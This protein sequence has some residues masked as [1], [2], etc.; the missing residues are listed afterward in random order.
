MYIVNYPSVPSIIHTNVQVEDKWAEYKQK[1]K[2]HQK[3]LEYRI[4]ALEADRLLN[5]SQQCV[6]Q[7]SQSLADGDYDSELWALLQVS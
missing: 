1:G 7:I 4:P 6:Q 2:V 3:V 5:Q